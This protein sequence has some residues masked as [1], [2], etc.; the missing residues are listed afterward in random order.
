MVTYRPSSKQEK[1]DASYKVFGT[2]PL[3]NCL[4]DQRIRVLSLM[5]N[6]LKKHTPKIQAKQ[7]MF[8]LPPLV[9]EGIPTPVQEMT[10]AQLRAFIPNMLKYSTGRGKP[11]WG[12]EEMK[13]VWWPQEVPWQNIRS[14]A[15]DDNQKKTIPWSDCLRKI[16]LSCY[17]HHN[18][19]DLLP[20]SSSV[21]KDNSLELV[22][23]EDPAQ[24]LQLLQQQ[25]GL[26]LTSLQSVGHDGTNGGISSLSDITASQVVSSCL[27]VFCSSCVEDTCARCIHAYV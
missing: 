21:E 15:R 25:H 12:K 23:S 24:Q 7:V 22:Q 20:S 8:D 19:A 2:S 27:F 18:R 11:G 14:D 10:Q 4:E 16:V 26:D 13:P 9:F 6:H 5:D 1:P 17:L 3:R